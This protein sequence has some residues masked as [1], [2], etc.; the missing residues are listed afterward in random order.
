MSDDERLLKRLRSGDI[1]AMNDIMTQY[2][3][4]VVTVIINQLGERATKED[5][6]ELASGVFC[7]L[8]E[9]RRS[10]RTDRLRG[11]LAA[12][13]RNSSLNH[14]R[15]HRHE[16]IDIDDI[17]ELSG[18]EYIESAAE[19]RERDEFIAQTLDTLDEQ[20]RE[21]FV[22]R[23]Y[24]GQNVSVIADEMSLNLSNVKSRLQRGRAKLR[25]ELIKG[26]YCCES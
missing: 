20:S 14:L 11:W 1:D 17:I 12:T 15:R 21:V 5:A 24:Y 3:P 8:W 13:A 23:Y 18:G 9:H 22:R 16:T 19:R 7:S 2:M 6:E 26:G 10:V 4:Y 25:D